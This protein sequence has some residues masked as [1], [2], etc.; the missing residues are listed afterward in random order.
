MKHKESEIKVYETRDYSQFK[1]MLGNRDAKSENKIVESIKT[2]GLIPNPIIVNDKME[3]ID[4][5]N[6]LA[7]LKQLELP[8]YYIVVDGLGIEECRQ[9]NIG[10]TNWGID[11]YVASFANQ[12]NADYQRLSS[13]LN[14]YR[15]P[16]GIDGVISMAKPS[17][18]NEGGSAPNKPLK[19]GEFK[20]SREEYELATTRLRSAIE[21]GY[22]DL[23]KRKQFTSK[24]FWACVS[25]IYQN[26]SV[27]AKDVIDALIEYEA[28]LPRCNRV[29]DQLA[30]FDDA[31][32]RGVRRSTDKIFLSTDFQKRL[33]MSR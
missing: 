5:Q 1:K 25:Y 2:V 22:A 4:G 28:I 20:L 31:I 33:Y 16:Y 32:N 11:D 24:I 17:F 18:I 10:Q 3:I 23:H 21:L 9:L 30:F 29:S 19:S 15:K 14:E 12:G 27:N 6:R 13:L 8:V 26:Q 7:A